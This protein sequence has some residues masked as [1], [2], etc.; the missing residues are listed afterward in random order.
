MKKRPLQ[1]NHVVLVANPITVGS[2]DIGRPQVTVGQIAEQLKP[3]APDPAATIER[4]RHWTRQKLLYPIAQHHAGTGK[5]RRY[6]D[7]SKFEVAILTAMAEAGL[8]IISQ[9]YLQKALSLTHRALQ[10]WRAN[11][12]LSLFLVISRD[13]TQ[14]DGPS[15]RLIEN[16]EKSLRAHVCLVM[17]LPLIF[18]HVEPRP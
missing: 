18:R 7:D 2:P 1:S 4:V 15:V 12:E 17:N 3:I 16:F 8:P 14:R 10:R 13:L 5:H 6:G 11:P 9:R